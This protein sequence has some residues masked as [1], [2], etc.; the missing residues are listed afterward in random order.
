MRPPSDSASGRTSWYER[1]TMVTHSRP[2]AEERS[3]DGGADDQQR[4]RAEQDPADHPA[5]GAQMGDAP[6][7][8]RGQGERERAG[9]AGLGVTAAGTPGCRSTRHV[10]SDSPRPV[11]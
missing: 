9:E 8:R 10:R 5:A 11:I 1:M 2:S 4:E 7:Q 6:D 3:G